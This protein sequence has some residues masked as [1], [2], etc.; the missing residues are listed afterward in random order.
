MLVTPMR[1]E[2]PSVKSAKVSHEM[3]TKTKACCV[4]YT[5]DVG[6][7]KRIGFVS[8][9]NPQA[10]DHRRRVKGR[11]SG[12]QIRVSVRSANKLMLSS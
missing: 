5:G 1:P 11:N 7:F 3:Q 12:M 4:S 9:S 6:I 2:G 8:P 10:T